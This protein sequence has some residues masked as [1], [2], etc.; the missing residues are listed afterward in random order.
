[1][2]AKILTALGSNGKVITD[3]IPELEFII[4][5]QPAVAEL[6]SQENSNRFYLVFQNFIKVF[7]NF[8]HPL[9]IFL[10]DLQWADSASLGLIK[11]LML[12]S[13]MRYLFLMLAY[14]DNETDSNHPFTIMLIL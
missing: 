13:S 2:E 3:V 7:A 14:R 9:A 6:G 11:N 12:D 8:E 5:E 1:M 4:G 10:D